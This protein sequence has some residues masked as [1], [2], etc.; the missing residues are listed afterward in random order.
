MRK[1]KNGFAEIP[2]ADILGKPNFSN[3]LKVL[4][5]QKPD[6][7]TLFE[8]F[9][10]EKLY[11]RLVKDYPLKE[12]ELINF[13][14]EMKAFENAGYDYYMLY[15]SNFN[16]PTSR[17]KHG[18]A[19]LSINEG[20][21]IHDRKSF[22]EYNWPNP[23][24]YDYSRLEK[25]A[26]DLPE[27]MRFIVYGPGG[28]LENVIALVGYET[29]CYMIIDDPDLAKDIFDAVGSRLVKYYE[30]CARYESVGALVSNDDWGFNTQT[31]LSLPDMRK[32]V[33][34]W[35]KKIVEVIHAAGKPA[36]LHSCGQLQN[37]MDDI[38]YDMKY[39][40]KHS[41][42]DKI[43]PVEEAYKKWGDKIAILGGIDLDF[44]CRSTPE[45]VYTRACRMLQLSSERGGYA[46]GS[47]NSIPEY[48]PQ[49]N[50]LALI[51]AA[52]VNRN[53]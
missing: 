19:S 6:R 23:E 17:S 36:I 50:Y 37:V 31:M 12:D 10:N 5:R 25:L 27:G 42:E 24:E 22:K 1:Y 3:L 43:L 13:R 45:E 9:M 44:V 47:G 39:D 46:L 48:V 16:F 29:L 33:F 21:G 53:M 51:S 15:G 40:A 18:K 38:I 52:L 28:V 2:S 32:Y 4:K 49:E 20:A 8:F 30:V 26:E 14:L 11:R 35:H 41:Y 7:F 34:G